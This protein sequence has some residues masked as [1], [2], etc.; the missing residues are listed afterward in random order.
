[1]NVGGVLWIEL[2]FAVTAKS[3][4]DGVIGKACPNKSSLTITKVIPAGPMFF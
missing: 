2:S 4:T 3:K 1:M